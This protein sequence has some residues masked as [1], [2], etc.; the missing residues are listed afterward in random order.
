MNSLLIFL[1]LETR[2]NPLALPIPLSHKRIDLKNPLPF[3]MHF[4]C[5]VWKQ[6]YNQQKIEGVAFPF[7][8][9]GLWFTNTWKYY[10]HFAIL[11]FFISICKTMKILHV[12]IYLW[13]GWWLLIFRNV[14]K[15]KYYNRCPKKHLS[16]YS[17]SRTT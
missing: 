8:I 4:W 15:R 5:G 11:S 7:Y 1:E 14:P 13:L 12:A 17:H 9:I 10:I 6:N 2:I 16:Q 3:I